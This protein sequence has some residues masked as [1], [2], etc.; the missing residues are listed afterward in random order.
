M[1]KNMEK[2]YFS[3][4][5]KTNIDLKIKVWEIY[6]LLFVRKK[7]EFFYALEKKEFFYDSEKSWNTFRIYSI[8]INSI[9]WYKPMREIEEGN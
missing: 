3:H 5:E 9:L 1:E 6:G 4:K 2:W 8:L 7:I